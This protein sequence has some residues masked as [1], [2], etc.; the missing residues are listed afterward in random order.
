M[1]GVPS[2][3]VLVFRLLVV[4]AAVIL[5]VA[6]DGIGRGSD[7]GIAIVDSIAGIS[8]VSVAT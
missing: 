7:G 3:P 6:A 5:L 1:V 2:T 4:L 8:H